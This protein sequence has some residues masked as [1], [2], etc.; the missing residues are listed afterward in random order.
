MSVIYAR[1]LVVV[2]APAKPVG[3]GDAAAVVCGAAKPLGG[4]GDK[5]FPLLL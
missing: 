3:D 5:S 2:T 1:D 4:V